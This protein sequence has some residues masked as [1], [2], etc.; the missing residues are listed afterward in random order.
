MAEIKTDVLSTVSSSGSGLQ[1]KSLTSSLVEAETS[2]ERTR[3]EQ[4]GS[5]HYKLVC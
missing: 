3:T 4:W 1:L 2:K 5:Y